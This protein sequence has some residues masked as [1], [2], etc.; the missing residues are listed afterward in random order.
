MLKVVKENMS[1]ESYYID[2]T[3]KEL[4]VMTKLNGICGVEKYNNRNKTK[5]IKATKYHIWTRRI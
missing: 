5:N 1:I 3:N 2:N 4:E